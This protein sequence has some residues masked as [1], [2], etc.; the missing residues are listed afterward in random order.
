MGDCCKATTFLISCCILI[1]AVGSLIAYL[2]GKYWKILSDT[3]FKKIRLWLIVA[4]AVI[5]VLLILCIL[6]SLC[7]SK[8]SRNL[9]SIILIIFNLVILAIA[10]IVF[11]FGKKVPT[12][13]S[14]KWTSGNL[15]VLIQNTFKC[16]NFE[17]H[18]EY[19]D[20]C[21]KDYLTVDCKGKADKVAS[22]VNTVGG[23]L[24]GIFVGFSL[25]IVILF[26]IACKSGD[27]DDSAIPTKDQFNT[28]LTY[29]W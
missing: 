21:S 26:W 14:D 28:P 3:N 4:L 9:V 12:I 24:I 13:V 22:S 23:I 29:G 11:I 15:G 1:G 10:I 2:L 18:K 25:I 8:F 6:L 16:C 7:N 19:K 17:S 20:N 27:N 5:V